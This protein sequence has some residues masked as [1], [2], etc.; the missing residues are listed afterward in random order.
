MAGALR[1]IGPALA[2][3]DAILATDDGTAGGDRS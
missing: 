2:L 3:A 1:R